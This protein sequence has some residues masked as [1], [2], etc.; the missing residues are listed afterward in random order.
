MLNP[1]FIKRKD[2]EIYCII[3]I[4]HFPIISNIEE[5]W[6]ITLDAATTTKFGLNHFKL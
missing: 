5:L 1:T 4:A 2:V 3:S 6:D